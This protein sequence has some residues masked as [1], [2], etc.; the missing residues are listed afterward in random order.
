MKQSFATG[1]FLFVLSAAFAQ[2]PFKYDSLYKKIY[3]R[4]ICTILQRHPDLVLIDVRTPGEFY[5][6]SRFASLN[7]GHLKGAVNLDIEDIKKDSSLVDKYKNSTV[8]L[9]CSHSQRS[10]KVS[11]LLSE[12]GF[13]NFYNLNGGMSSLTQLSESE[14]PC[15]NDWIISNVPYKNSSFI[16]AA[17]LIQNEK[18]LVIIDIRS[19]AQFN[20][21]DTNSSS[22]VGKIKNAI[23]VPYSEFK[24]RINELVKYKQKPILLYG[25]SGDGNPARASLELASSGFT[26][27]YQLLGGI[28]DFIASQGTVGFIDNPAPY[29]VLNTPRSLKLLKESK[30]IIVYDTRRNEEYNNQLTGITA[31]R[32]LGRIKNA[33]HVEEKN[34]QSQLLPADKNAVILIYGEEPAYR[35]ASLLTDRGYKNVNIMDNFY[36][37]VWSG[38]NVESCKETKAF[39]V[40]HQGLYGE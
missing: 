7:L 39:L 3:A 9:Y 40:N 20:S 33:M 18:E 14:F 38:F 11:K 15:K 21:K 2:L 16:E 5:D 27:V 13:H 19:A 4:D 1:I 32:N 31:Y 26:K 8:V 12:K 29:Q 17:N 6:T 37:F 30:N 10:R 34:F 28:N 23:N 36:D 24:Q 25:E 22:N 35:L